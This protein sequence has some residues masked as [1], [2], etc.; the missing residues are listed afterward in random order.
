MTER[1]DLDRFKRELSLDADAMSDQRDA[2]NEDMRFVAV[3]GGQWEGF[4]ESAY[5]NNRVK[6][7]FDIVSGYKN[8]AL[9]EWNQNRVGVEYKPDDDATSDDDAELLTG[10][11]R[12]DFRDG[13]GKQAVKNAV[14]EALTCGFGAWHIKPVYED[15]EDPESEAQRIIWEPLFNAYNSVFF[16]SAA[17]REDKKDARRCTILIPYTEESFLEQWPGEKPVSAYTPTDRSYLNGTFASKECIFVATRYQVIKRKEKAFIYNNLAT[18]E[19]EVYGQD[20]HK[21][22]ESTLKGS[23]I[24]EFVREKKVT[25][26]Y[27][28]IVRFSG[29][30]ILEGPRRIAGKWIGVVPVYGYRSY[31]DGKEWY[32][33]VVRKL[34]D[35]A[36]VMNVQLSQ[37][38]EVAAGG[39]DRVP[40]FDPDQMDDENVRATWAERTNNSFKL[41][42]SLVDNDGKVSHVGPVGYVEPP[43]IGSAAT[44]LLEFVGAFVRD[45]T[46][47]A[48]Q[49]V[50]DPA[51]SGKAIQA[52]Q[53]REDRNTQPI[54][55]NIA[56][57]IEHSGVVYQSLA[58]E[59][60]DTPRMVRTL[61]LDGT[62]GRETLFQIVA[63]PKT[64]RL[65]ES[66]TLRGKRFRAYSDI[67]PQYE[68]MREQTV[69]ELKGMLEVM[70][71]VQGGE[72]YIPVLVDSLLQ[73]INGVGLGPLKKKVRQSMLLQ[74]LI[75]PESDDDHEFM[76]Q[77]AQPREDPQQKLL[78]AAAAQQEA[79]ARNLDAASAEKA[80]GAELKVA[81]TRKTEAE[82]AQ[83]LSEM[84]N[85]RA[86]TLAEIRREVLGQ[87][88]QG[89]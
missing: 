15:E 18:G 58:G 56:D 50:M 2:A 65:I 14:N 35:A 28:E 24:H 12:A 70:S 27:V 38:I 30:A 42:H 62:H 22:S 49:D 41:A 40:I 6:A 3:D 83:T 81:Q 23:D 39:G 88:S 67:G 46:G 9:A 63:D 57:G 20:E 61:G 31:V 1:S 17:Q 7:E 16:D 85:N 89:L 74:G 68:S 43:V 34:K 45:M 76:A 51:S 10:M 11:Y 21:E 37:I 87:A 53:K 52:L 5:T 26:R 82:T 44:T 4:L 13:D 73:N 47:G 55:E 33:G 72:Q 75:E 77:A 64:G 25:V 19:V 66:N 78:A 29:D 60:Y 48:P 54:F 80:A 8:R 84:T 59:V 69:E 79:E 36:R 71:G 32:H 86:R